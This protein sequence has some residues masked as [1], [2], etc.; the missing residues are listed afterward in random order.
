M[1]RFEGKNTVVT[2][3][4][5]GL[6]AVVSLLFAKEGARVLVVDIDLSSAEQ[7]VEQ[8]RAMGGEA[9]P[10]STDVTSAT[11]VGQM[12]DCLRQ[13]YGRVDILVNNA[14]IASQ[15]TVTDL[16][17]EDWDRVMDVNVKGAYL[18]SRAAVPQMEEAR[19]GSIICISSASGVIGQRGQ[20][21]Y[22]ASKHAL[23][24]LVRC[25]AL[26]HAAA[27]IRV[28]AVCPG[29]MKTPMLEALSD[30]QL[31]DLYAMHPIG[32]IAEPSEV[33]ETVL[34]LAGDEASFTTGAVFLVD[35]GLTAM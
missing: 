10:I 2:G 33:A 1:A 28:N 14:G 15:G 24:G 35:G 32:R 20:V 25:M 17:E 8:I 12:M 23:I 16:S 9:T 6:G 5:R 34:H 26:D 31:A 13:R 3:A 29:V 22:N 21:A 4:G 11:E 18:C 27:G 7:T 30:D 19:A